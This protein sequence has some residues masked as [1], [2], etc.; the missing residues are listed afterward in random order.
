MWSNPQETAGLVAFTEKILNGKLDFLCSAILN[1]WQG[2]KITSG[3]LKLFYHGSKRDT[4]ESLYMP[5]KL[6]IAFTPN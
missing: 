4:R 6:I 3:L 2:S 5:N 1:V